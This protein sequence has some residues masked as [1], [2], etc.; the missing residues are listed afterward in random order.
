MKKEE[1][2]IKEEEMKV[3]KKDEVKEEEEMELMKK[4][5]E[6][7]DE[8]EEVIEKMKVMKM[9]GEKEEEME[10]MKKMK[11]EE[12]E[13]IME[14]TEVMEEER[15]RGDGGKKKETEKEE[16]IIRKGGEFLS[17]QHFRKFQ[18]AHSLQ[19][20][21][22]NVSGH[23]PLDI[24]SGSD[25]DHSGDQ[26]PPISEQPHSSLHPRPMSTRGLVTLSLL[27]LRAGCSGPCNMD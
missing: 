12:G 9:D 13:E 10:L 26:S 24:L 19:E 4:M 2:E 1:K 25:R 7:K 27:E 8:E 14:V 23:T 3:M 21:G 17:N 18:T 20:C 5:K 16:V 22:V 15:E 6:K 11:K